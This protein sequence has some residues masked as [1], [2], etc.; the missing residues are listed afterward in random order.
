MNIVKKIF[1]VA[2]FA[3]FSVSVY[4]ATPKMISEE[5]VKKSKGQLVLN[6]EKGIYKIDLKGL[7]TDKITLIGKNE[8]LTLKDWLER[9]A[10]IGYKPKKNGVITMTGD[11]SR[12]PNVSPGTLKGISGLKDGE[13]LPRIESGYSSVYVCM[14]VMYTCEVDE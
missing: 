13:M 2:L 12:F 7:S 6:I 9:A 4:G 1:L 5:N 3:V 11:P 10:K 14:L 8:K